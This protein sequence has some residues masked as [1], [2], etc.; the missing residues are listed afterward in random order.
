MLLTLNSRTFP[1]PQDIFPDCFCNLTT[2]KFIETQQMLITE[3]FKNTVT[4][5]LPI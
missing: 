4:V 5:N 3:H 2:Y 1:G